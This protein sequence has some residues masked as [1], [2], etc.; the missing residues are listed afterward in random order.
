MRRLVTSL[1]LW[2]D[3]RLLA[4]RAGGGGGWEGVCTAQSFWSERRLEHRF[5]MALNWSALG[6]RVRSKGRFSQRRLRNLESRGG[7]PGKRTVTHGTR[8]PTN[9][10]QYP[11]ILC[12]TQ[13]IAG[14]FLIMSTNAPIKGVPLAGVKGWW[15]SG[16]QRW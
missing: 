10:P 8:I 9:A 1:R 13:H 15:G 11:Q 5:Q 12:A 6:E 16:L 2:V 4:G 14:C 7:G 3:G